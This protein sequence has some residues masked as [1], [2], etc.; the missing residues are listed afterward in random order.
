MSEDGETTSSPE[1]DNDL[2]G[3][4]LCT[5]CGN[6]IIE[7]GVAISTIDGLF[8]CGECVSNYNEELD[9]SFVEH[10]GDTPPLNSDEDDSFAPDACSGESSGDELES[11]DS[12]DLEQI[13]DEDE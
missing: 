11:L 13:V 5:M 4:P 9:T 3:I 10:N 12:D 1:M 6:P 8:C 2:Q 7:S